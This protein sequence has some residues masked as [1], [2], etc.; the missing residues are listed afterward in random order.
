MTATIRA[1]D[2]TYQQVVAWLDAMIEALRQAGTG[3]LPLTA[4]VQLQPTGQT[5]QPAADLVAAGRESLGTL[6][7][8][9]GGGIDAGTGGTGLLAILTNLRA[10]LGM[11]RGILDG[12][13]ERAADLA[14]IPTEGRTVAGTVRPLP[15]RVPAD[16]WYRGRGADG[17]G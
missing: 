6:S 9:I 16:A 2:A 1:D 17:G 14:V 8:S 11:T 3:P 7:T 12:V 5:W 15:V 13:E 4:D 10:G